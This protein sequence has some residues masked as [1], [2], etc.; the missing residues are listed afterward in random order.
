MPFC[1]KLLSYVHMH[2]LPNLI[3]PEPLLSFL[4][5]GFWI[6]KIRK[7]VFL[8]K[9]PTKGISIEIPK[10]EISSFSCLMIL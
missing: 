7:T 4:Y 6:V 1:A 3:V 9:T 5:G 2:E 10:Q 8:H